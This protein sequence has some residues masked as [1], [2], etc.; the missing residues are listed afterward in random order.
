VSNTFELNEIIRT[1]EI[2]GGHKAELE[3]EVKKNISLNSIY[4]STSKIQN[5][6]YKFSGSLETDVRETLISLGTSDSK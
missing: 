3:F 5:E 4:V 1:I 6:G 2:V